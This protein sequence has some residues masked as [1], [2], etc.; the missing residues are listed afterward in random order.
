MRAKQVLPANDFV[1]ISTCWHGGLYMPTPE[2]LGTNIGQTFRCTVRIE[3]E[4]SAGTKIHQAEELLLDLHD[5]AYIA[6]TEGD[7]ELEQYLDQRACVLRNEISR[8]QK[9]A[10]MA[11]V[12]V[13]D[14][15]K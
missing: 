3:P 4:L 10:G 14:D 5:Q 12:F 6:F 11:D 2:N 7:T 1:S 8:W 9:A 13:E 15:E